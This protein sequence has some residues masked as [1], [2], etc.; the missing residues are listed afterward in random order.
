MVSNVIFDG[1]VSNIYRLL[2]SSTDRSVTKN[3]NMVIG[4]AI[5]LSSSSIG[6]FI[7]VNEVGKTGYTEIVD[8][9]GMVSGDQ[10]SHRIFERA[11][12]EASL[13]I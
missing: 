10:Q 11:T 1:Y 7:N 3:P 12:M 2:S 8:G 13:R 9:G 4:A 6:H 5:D